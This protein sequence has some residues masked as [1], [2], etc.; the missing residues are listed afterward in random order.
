MTHSASFN[1]ENYLDD[2]V[3]DAAAVDS[4]GRHNH[5]YQHN[6]CQDGFQSD[7]PEL[8]ELRARC[9]QMEK[10]MRW[11]SECT[12]NW[13]DKW[14]KVRTERNRLKDD[15]KR[16]TARHEVTVDDLR[17]Q[18]QQ[19]QQE[20]AHKVR[21][22]FPGGHVSKTYRV[23]QVQT[24]CQTTDATSN[25]SPTM[26]DMTVNSFARVPVN[27]E[28]QSGKHKTRD[29]ST[30]SGVMMR[31][32]CSLTGCDAAEQ[33][34]V[35]STNQC[36]QM[37][38]FLSDVS[39]LHSAEQATMLQLRLDEAVKTLRVE[40]E[41]KSQLQSE[42]ETL[43]GQVCSFEVKCDELTLD[44]VQIQ[45][46]L[47]CLRIE[48]QDQSKVYARQL[49]DH[50]STKHNLEQ[51]VG[52]L[53]E[54]LERLQAENAEEWGRRERLETEKHS[55]ERDNRKLRAQV[56]ELKERA[57]R[58]TLHCRDQTSTEVSRLQAELD[59]N[60]HDLSDLKHSHSKLRKVLNEKSDELTHWQR[61]GDTS[62]K[63]VKALRF[64]IEQLKVELGEAQDE[65]DN[66]ANTIRRLQRTNEEF[67]GQVEGLEVQVEHLTS[68]LRS[69]PSNLMAFRR[70]SRMSA[71][72]GMASL[73]HHDADCEDETSTDENEFGE[74]DLTYVTDDDDDDED[75][76]ETD[77]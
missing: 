69:M 1:Y 15:L 23:Q 75:V 37:N 57:Q 47:D 2:D 54:E 11:W 8:E 26:F 20:V 61:K 70:T 39:A 21:N 10:T 52:H 71:P 73:S 68:R 24:D 55:V 40:R 65:I 3:E 76:N 50:V 42:I 6:K 4:F 9:A 32:T 35:G 17:K 44:K 33:D 45:R 36:E 51:I 7:N 72:G 14:S 53:R 60:K 25:T 22:Y 77:V 59:Q 62:D 34:V 12:A 28:E 29:E 49:D 74:Q 43:H 66:S 27:H 19:Q 48:H 31:T 58:L 64:R 63:E 38:R 46:D 16:L 5:F 18:L 13:R 30:D 41:D 56:D 67:A